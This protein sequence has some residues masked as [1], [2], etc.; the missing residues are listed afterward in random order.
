M[1]T[2]N[3]EIEDLMPHRIRIQKYENFDDYGR[4]TDAAPTIRTYRCLID[5]ATTIVRNAEGQEVT[6]A[7]T[8]YVAPVPIESTDGLPVD[9]DKNDNVDILSPREQLDKP[10]NSI[11]RHYDSVNGVGMLHNIVLRF[12]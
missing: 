6:V 11:E 7:L 12:T 1:T 2:A 10:I 3:E 5:D 9:I 8:A 4:P